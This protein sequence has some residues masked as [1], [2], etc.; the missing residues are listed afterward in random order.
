VSRSASAS[1]DGC[2]K[3]NLPGSTSWSDEAL[4][5]ILAFALGLARRWCRGREDAEDVA[6]EAVIRLLLHAPPERPRAWLAVVVRRLAWTLAQARVRE[7]AA[8]A[9]IGRL[10]RRADA[11]DRLQARC[12]ARELLERASPHDLRLLRLDGLGYDHDEIGR[13]VGCRARSVHTLLSRARRRLRRRNA[14]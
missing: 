6:Q 8:I 3:E 7:A 4:R 11:S 1:T 5:D 14:P 13:R 2:G 12:A 10:D 9:E